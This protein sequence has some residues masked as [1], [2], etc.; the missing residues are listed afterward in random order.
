MNRQH[1]IALFD[2]WKKSH[3]WL[4]NNT[5][6]VDAFFIG[7]TVGFPTSYVRKKNWRANEWIGLDLNAFVQKIGR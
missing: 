5:M 7:K 4:K 3:S 1:T 6:N 2:P